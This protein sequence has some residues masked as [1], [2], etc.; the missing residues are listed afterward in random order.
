MTS[1][2]HSLVVLARNYSYGFFF[3]WFAFEFNGN[4][5]LYNIIN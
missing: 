4:V 2:H 1:S 3:F 5:L